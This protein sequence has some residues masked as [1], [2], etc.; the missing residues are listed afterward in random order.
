[1]LVMGALTRDEARV[2]VEADADVVAWREDF[3]RAP[4]G[5]ARA[6]T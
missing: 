1:M 6:C 5:T 4:P 2:A 3:V